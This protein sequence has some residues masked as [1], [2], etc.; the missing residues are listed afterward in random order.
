MLRTQLLFKKEY[1][2]QLVLDLSG[3]LQ[4][5]VLDLSG[6]LQSFDSPSFFIR[7]SINM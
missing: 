2:R 3:S 7:H 1:K 4:Q 5:L 6:S